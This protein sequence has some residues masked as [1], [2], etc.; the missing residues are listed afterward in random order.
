MAYL[1][2]NYYS[3]ALK[4]RTKV[5]VILPE[6]S[7]KAEGSGIGDT[8]E[9]K[10]LYL[11][12][13]L[14]SDNSVW[15]RYTSVERYAQ[16]YNIAVIMP[17]VDRSWYTDTAYGINYFTFVAKELP[18]VCRGYFKGMSGKREDNFIAGYSMG[19]YGALKIALTYPEDYM[20]CA[21][22]SGAL[23]ITRKNRPINIE[24]WRSI[25]GFDMKSADELNGTKHD[26]Y[27]LVRK[28]HK[29]GEKF[30][31]MYLWCGTEDDKYILENN[32]TFH[33]LLEELDIEH[34]YKDSEGNH[35]FKWWDIYIQEALEY[36]LGE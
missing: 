10:T 18:E 35:T 15:M 30:P 19:G 28:N 4:K 5:N 24:E 12:H 29:N 25:F 1:E 6:V 36:L 2:F 7:K 26:V 11:L 27:E 32:R 31:K 16:K 34:L 9:Y 3:K 33:K 14:S 8:G 21:S 17:E 13:G 23:D 20:G 22:L